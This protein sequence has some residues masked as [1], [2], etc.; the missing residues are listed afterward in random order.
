MSLVSFI[1]AVMLN[2]CCGFAG[3]SFFQKVSFGATEFP[4]DD[5]DFV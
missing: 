2:A 4:V 3:V 1:V 5:F